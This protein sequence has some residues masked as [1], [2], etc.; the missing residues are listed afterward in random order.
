MAAK[1]A[2]QSAE[3]GA[4]RPVEKSAGKNAGKGEKSAGKSAAK[5]PECQ[6]NLAV[7]IGVCS[8]PPE[9][10]VLESGTRVASLSVRAPA[11]AG[12]RGGRATD[13]RVAEAGERATSVPVTVWD[14]PA[15]VEALEPGEAIVV[16]GQVRRRFYSRPGGVGSRVDLEAVSIARARDRRRVDAA[17]RR[18]TSLLDDLR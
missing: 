11:H 16:V 4:G 15:W 2:E 18:A 3:Q 7:V 14:P 8:A 10:R 9:V 1:S 6:L 17:L 12:G 5:V 13:A